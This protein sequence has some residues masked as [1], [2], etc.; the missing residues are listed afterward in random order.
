MKGIYKIVNL[1]NGKFYIGSCVNFKKRKTRH[2][3]DLKKNRHH[4]LLLQRAFN[5]YGIENFI[6]EFIEECFDI[7]KVEQT[8]LNKIDFSKSYNVSRFASGGDRICGNPNEENIRL[9]I[10]KTNSLKRPKKEKVLKDK[11]VKIGDKNSNW[12][13]GVSKRNCISC[14]VEINGSANKCASCY[15]KERDISNVKNPFYGK[16]HSQESKRKIS[17]SH[18]GIYNGNQEKIVL[19]DGIEYKS[20]SELARILKVVPGTILNR[21]K[22]KN[23]PNYEYRKNSNDYPEREYI[24]S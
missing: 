9:K 15:Y 13:G 2:L 14:D 20:L 7:L 24:T 8:Y 11:I 5:K 3:M 18:L 17:Q 22:S 6:F 21:I 23:Y 19:V 16:V 12:K 4:S 1:V 10:K